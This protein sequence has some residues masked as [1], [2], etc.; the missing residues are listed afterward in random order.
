VTEC[1]LDHAADA[2]AYA[3]SSGLLKRKKTRLLDRMIHPTLFTALLFGV[4]MAAA[5]LYVILSEWINLL[6]AII[7]AF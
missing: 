6:P 7:G 5:T 4:V 3:V 1:D 2:M